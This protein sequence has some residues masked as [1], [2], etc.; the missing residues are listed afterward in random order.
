MAEIKRPDYFTSQFL[1]E[2]D[3]NDEQTYHV[4]SRRRH[5]RVSHT[6][7]VADGFDVTRLAATQVQISP[8]T[9]IDSNGREIVLND[10][11]QYTL[12]TG[13]NNLDLF[14]TISY[15]EAFDP[16]DH[17]TLG[18]LDKFNRTTERPLVQDVI[19]A[20]PTDGSV[21]V[22]ARIHLGAT[23]AIDGPSSIDST[24]RTA[25]SAKLAA[26]AV[27]TTQLADGSVTL[28]K[29]A[30]EALP[31]AV[32]AA[33]AITVAT[34][35]TLKQITVGENHSA[36]ADNPHGTTAAQIDALAGANQIVT[37][38]NAGTGIITRAHLEST[39]VSG[40]ATFQNLGTGIEMFSNDI[41]PGF[42]P[43]ALCVDLALDDLPSVNLTSSGDTNYA[44]VVQFRSEINRTTGHFR[45]FVLRNTA[46]SP[47]TVTVRWYAFKPLAG[48]NASVGIGVVV[49]PPTANL[50][51]S[52]TQTFTATVS[53]T[54]NTGVT[55]SA[56]AG[57]LSATSGASVTYTPPGI[58]GNYQVKAT[59]VADSNGFGT[60]SVNVNADITVVMSQ[61][62]A[63]VVRGTQ[64]TLSANVINTPTTTVT[65]SI[66][67]GPSGGSLSSTTGNSIVY[68]APPSTQ[69]TFTVRATSTANTT[70]FGQ[71][72]ITVPPVSISIA[73]DNPNPPAGA[74]SMI[75]RA[76]ITGTTDNRANWVSESSVCTVSPA[77][78]PTTTW[79]GPGLGGSFGVK[80]TAVA[81]TNK[82]DET[83]INVPNIPTGGGGGGGGG[84]GGGGGPIQPLSPANPPPPD[85]SPDPSPPAS[86]DSAV[87]APASLTSTASTGTPVSAGSGASA[88]VV[89][90]DAATAAR[91]KKRA[92]S[93][94]PPDA[95]GG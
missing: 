41:D 29:L 13:G 94:A 19:T 95:A 4:D 40:V 77:V 58:S 30:N 86:S 74:S 84:S 92:S 24:V 59:S 46:S 51:G 79:T 25:A 15:Q 18:G 45:I 10:P 23:G 52:A 35:N 62:T 7:G 61:L 56:T 66:V 89:A 91:P 9:A 70:K 26:K 80:A 63:T 28:A 27:S 6:T 37:Q 69:G 34:D 81:D 55:W 33:N 71:C 2:K 90:D 93:K 53:N 85:S 20:P 76:T 14:L 83:F 38:I 17:Y 73:A 65:W 31:M 75:V 8:G 43:G 64:L 32:K 22:L 44:R 47:G 88:P 78:G 82:F 67:E 42:G 48:A 12:T 3:F 72:I 60:A 57:Q 1:V 54:T 16:A 11:K 36:R 21:I 87:V 39:V 5:N 68:T 50:I 49:S